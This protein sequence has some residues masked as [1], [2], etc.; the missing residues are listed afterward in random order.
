MSN[1]NEQT[2]KSSELSMLLLGTASELPTTAA[3][4]S[5][6]PLLFARKKT[7]TGNVS[8]SVGGNVNDNGDLSH[9]DAAQASLLLKRK[10]ASGSSAAA[11]SVNVRHR[12]HIK[13]DYHDLIE[14]EMKLGE[15]QEHY[16]ETQEANEEEEAEFQLA[17][18]HSKKNQGGKTTIVTQPRGS[19]RSEAESDND[20]RVRRRKRGHRSRSSSSSSSSDESTGRRRIRRTESSS[21]SDSDDDSVDRRARIR[22]RRAQNRNT[23]AAADTDSDSSIDEVDKRR[24]RSRTQKLLKQKQQHDKNEERP[25]R[26]SSTLPQDESSDDDN[27]NVSEDIAKKNVL[28]RP[29]DLQS[30][31]H[32]G[33][34]HSRGRKSSSSCESESDSS[35]TSSSDE[36][37]SSSDDDDNVL[38]TEK[39]KPMF[40]PRHQRKKL[41]EQQLKAQ[42]QEL[43]LEEQ[44]QSQNERR[45]RQSRAM[46]AQVVASEQKEKELQSGNYLAEGGGTNG[47]EFA[48]GSSSTIPPPNDSDDLSPLEREKEVQNWEMRELARLVREMEEYVTQEQEVRE[49]ERRRKMT[50]KERYEEDVKSGRYRKPGEQRQNSDSNAHMQRYFHRGAFYMD[51]DTLMQDK[52]DVRHRASEYA[53]A[54]T[55]DDVFDKR[56]MPKVMQAK[57]FGFAGYSTKY[58]GLTKEDTTDKGVDFLPVGRVKAGENRTSDRYR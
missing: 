13:R 28:T 52:D 16:S 49:L 20:T 58:K 24:Q 53:K 17:K 48:N 1:Q 45:I 19:N 27:S 30:K 3:A 9:L 11:A 14:S 46:V 41:Q 55:G 37:S 56:K 39:A 33:Q 21:S 54:A 6:N 50:D 22:K 4:Q 32:R 57:K 25:S 51:D 29:A 5:S 10:H 47:D 36:S 15:K 31:L 35:S 18:K 43:R 38:I 26:N 42:A 44:I 2:M 23:N 8:A 7:T 34:N 12:R 40:V